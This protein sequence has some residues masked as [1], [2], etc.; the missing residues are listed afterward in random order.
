MTNVG[1]L[2]QFFL[3][4]IYWILILEMCSG[5]CD[6]LWK[7]VWCQKQALVQFWG[8][9]LILP[10]LYICQTLTFWKNYRDQSEGKMLFGLMWFE[11]HKQDFKF[12][13]VT[14]EGKCSCF[15]FWFFV[16]KPKQKSVTSSCMEIH[17]LRLCMWQQVNPTHYFANLMQISH[18]VDCYSGAPLVQHLSY[19]SRG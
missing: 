15:V 2:L 14:M 12:N 7:R 9:L 5:L 13:K 3:F 17:C 11:R 6:V 8:W 16:Y 18:E 19:H 1:D 4:L 10:L